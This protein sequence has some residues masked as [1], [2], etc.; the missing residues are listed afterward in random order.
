[1]SI[2]DHN[3]PSVYSSCALSCLVNQVE[4]K[5]QR[6]PRTLPTGKPTALI[7]PATYCT[8]CHNQEKNP[9]YL[10]GRLAKMICRMNEWQYYNGRD[11]HQKA[12]DVLQDNRSR[13]MVRRLNL[14]EDATTVRTC[15]NCHALPE[16]GEA[17]EFLADKL[18]L[19]EG[20]TCV[21]CHGPY[22]EWVEAHPNGALWRAQ[23]EVNP[24]RLGPE[25][26]I[27]LD[28]KKKELLKGMTDLWDPVRRA[29]V[30]A[31]CHIGN[32]KQK[33]LI[34]HAMFAAGHPP[35]PG[36]EAA[37]F[38]EFQ[39]RHWEYLRE[40]S[41]EKQKRLQPFN[42][43]NL[44]Q[45]ELVAVTGLVVLRESMRLFADQAKA[46]LNDPP[47]AA[48]PDLARYDCLACHHELRST[49]QDAFRPGL[50]PG[51]PG[52]PAWAHALVPLSIKG[53]TDNPVGADKQQKKYESLL[54]S[55]HEVLSAPTIWR[56]AEVDPG[57]GESLGL[58]G[59]VIGGSLIEGSPGRDNRPRS[60]PGTPP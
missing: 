36:F 40:K 28:R 9:T 34:T 6:R 52:E 31:S 55:L 5:I 24:D 8:G 50:L 1:M 57:S 48:W 4:A 11:K 7:T 26:W 20:V 15:L 42:S 13:E 44:E 25:N 3:C 59:P 54:H 17:G 12:F 21:A 46:N 58:G 33:K 2:G 60:S 39:P 49:N 45:A 51:R 27:K 22:S 35:L 56:Q 19:S 30:C 43:K 38:S 32:F 41:G 14:G 16:A 47:G 23:A 29:E 18:Q 37:T 10:P 53:L